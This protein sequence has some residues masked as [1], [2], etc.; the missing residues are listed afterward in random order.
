[1]PAPPAVAEDPEGQRWYSFLATPP[2]S[3]PTEGASWGSRGF[4]EDFFAKSPPY[5]AVSFMPDPYDS[6]RS[7]TAHSMRSGQPSPFGSEQYPARSP[8]RQ[9]SRVEVLS[10]NADETKSDAQTSADAHPHGVESVD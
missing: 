9:S 3:P 10:S 8:V 6:P 1:M 4:A 5:A 7:A 2:R